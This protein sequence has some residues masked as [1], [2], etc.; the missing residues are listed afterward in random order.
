[1]NVET[2]DGGWIPQLGEQPGPI[3][4]AIADALSEAVATGKLRPGNRLPT[5]RAM[6]E[7]LGV[8]LTTVTRAYA[9]ARKR[10][11][12]EAT[13]GRG[14][15]VR[16]DRKGSAPGSDGRRGSGT[17]DLSMN[18][19]PRPERPLVDALQRGFSSLLARPDVSDLLTYRSGSGTSDE[20]TA[21]AAWL[22]PT[23]GPVDPERVLVSPGAQPALLAILGMVAKPGDVVL[24]DGFT[25]PGVRAAAAQLGIRLAGIAADEHGMLPDAMADACRMEPRAKALYCI[26]TVHNPTAA[27]MPRARREAIAE[28]ARKCGL[29]IVEDDAYGLLPSAPLPAIASLAPDITFHVATA[30]KVLSPALRVAFLVAPDQRQAARLN[31]IL[32]ANVQMPSPLLTGLTAAWVG[33]GTSG[34]IIEAIRRECAARQRIARQVLADVPFDAHPEGL[35][36]WLHLPDRWSSL[37]FTAYLRRQD[38]L[39]VVPSDVFAVAGSEPAPER[40]AAVRISLGAAPDRESLRQALEMVASALKQDTSMI[41]SE[42]V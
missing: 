21:G 31:S 27:T 36:V 23:V 39:A 37:G 33:D 22:L 18:L 15:F 17:L 19:P 6:A 29:C 41:F 13:V 4:L 35:H 38:G 5:H 10:G 12:L 11:V 25:Y 30:S 8:D 9:E 34:A 32:R 24:T 20:R 7:A 1:M 28:A 42:V 3:Y 26:P 2:A 14:T 40:T 16:A